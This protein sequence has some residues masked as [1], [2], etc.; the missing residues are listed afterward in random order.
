MLA[1]VND[2]IPSASDLAPRSQ[3]WARLRRVAF[4]AG[5]FLLCLHWLYAEVH[6][7][8]GGEGERRARA[9]FHAL[10]VAPTAPAAAA[11]GEEESREGRQ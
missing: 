5:H 1:C 8:P 10:A 11:A 2:T 3:R 9:E 4:L 6:W 7:R